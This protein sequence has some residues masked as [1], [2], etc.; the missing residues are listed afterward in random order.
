MAVPTPEVRNTS[1]GIASVGIEELEEDTSDD[2]IVEC[3]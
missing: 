2:G 3:D 1:D